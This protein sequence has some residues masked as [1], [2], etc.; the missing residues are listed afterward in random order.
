MPTA[1]LHADGRRAVTIKARLA[2]ETTSAEVVSTL[3]SRLEALSEIWPNGY[4]YRIRGEAESSSETFGGVGTA[5]LA[6]VF[7]VFAL[8][9]LQYGSFKLPGIVMV[10]VPLSLTGVGYGFF[11]LGIPVSFPAMIGVIALIG[12]AVNNAIVMVEVINSRL[13]EGM[14]LAAAAAHGASDRLR[15]I[16]TTTVTTI[17]G[18]LPL[19]LS[20]P[21]WYP[22]CMSVVLGL[23]VATVLSLV[24]VPSMFVLLG[25][26]PSAEHA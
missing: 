7:L 26:K 1:L 4:S 14:D 8:L 24:V 22:L 21:A 18:L 25:P 5:M 12:I 15:P 20:S 16:L 19:A 2:G 23:L 11:A 10:T 17:A 9:S 3:G 6:A 13:L